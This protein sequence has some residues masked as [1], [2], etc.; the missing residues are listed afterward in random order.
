MGFLSSIGKI[1]SVVG[2][3]T[4]NPYISAAG[5]IAGAIG[6]GDGVDGVTA[7]QNAGTD[8]AM[9]LQAQIYNQNRQDMMPW[10]NQGKAGINRLGY[11]LGTSPIDDKTITEQFGFNKAGTPVETRA[12]IP[13]SDS[14][15]QY[16]QGT[17][18]LVDG[19]WTQWEPGNAMNKIS[20]ENQAKI[21]AE[22][23][24]QKNDP[25]YGSLTKSFGKEDFQT[26]PGYDFR[27]AEGQ[28]AIE[29][30][31]AA[32]GGLLSGAAIKA[33]NRFSQDTASN[34]YQNAYNRF[35]QNQTNLYNRL[36]G[37]AGSGQTAS[38]NLASQG[39]TYANNTGSLLQERAN[40]NAAGNVAQQNAFNTGLSSIGSSLGG[41]F[42]G[43][44]N[45][46]IMGGY[47]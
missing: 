24:R 16:G 38:S 35:N 1:A 44:S 6:G 25:A 41:L 47:Y 15:N 21:D 13:G 14:Y 31:A 36:A 42:G 11:L 4:G 2:A 9:N 18:Y 39:Q 26:D 5:Q 28:K 46:G 43:G 34:E 19:S 20:P 8:A 12:R 33:A 23:A 37:I 29:R 7:Q 45:P 30:S 10:L 22:I 40:T 32:K 27:M 17:E 3:V